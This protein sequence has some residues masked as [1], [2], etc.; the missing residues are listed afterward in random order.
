MF[1][2]C[3]DVNGVQRGTVLSAS[4]TEQGDSLRKPGYPTGLTFLITVLSVV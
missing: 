4:C 1:A 3:Y 2:G